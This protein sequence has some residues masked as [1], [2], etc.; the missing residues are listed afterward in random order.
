MKAFID[1]LTEEK[2]CI[3]Y[4]TTT[5]ETIVAIGNVA[6]KQKLTIDQIEMLQFYSKRVVELDERLTKIQAEI[7]NSIAYYLRTAKEK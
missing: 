4:K 6:R 3:N 5:A 2:N 7:G 1:L